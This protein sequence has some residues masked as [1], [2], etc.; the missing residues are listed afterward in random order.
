MFFFLPE[1]INLERLNLDSC[2]IGDEG[3]LHLKG[4]LFNVIRISSSAVACVTFSPFTSC[5]V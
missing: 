3:L 4:E 5:L 2:K 1:L